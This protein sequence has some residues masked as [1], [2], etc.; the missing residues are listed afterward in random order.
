MCSH[1]NTSI[2]SVIYMHSTLMYAEVTNVEID[3]DKQRV[4]VTST[5]S[6]DEL[7]AAI[8]KTG[9]QCSYIGVS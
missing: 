1:P 6:S 9:R 4:Y 7:L 3:M 5:L 2:H 8:K